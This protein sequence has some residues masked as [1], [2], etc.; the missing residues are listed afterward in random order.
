MATKEGDVE[1]IREGLTFKRYFTTEGTAPVRR[2]GLGDPRRGDPQLQGGRQRLRA[3]RR[4]VPHLLVAERHQ[5]RGPEVLPRDPRDARSAS[6]RVRQLAGRVVDTIRGWGEKNGYFASRGGRPGLR[7]GA[8]APHRHPEGGLQ[9][10]GLV[11]RRRAR[12]AA[13]VLRLLHPRGRRPHELHPQLVRRGGHHLQGRVGLRDQ[14]LA[15]SA[16][17]R[18][19]S[20]GAA[21][22]RA[23]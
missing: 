1:V 14:P 7:R 20:P 2:R 12:H 17:P 23:R 19:R 9:L 4:G 16:R 8:H 22:P 11:Q 18:S 5:H 15:R 3:A 10:A 6:P 13:A 21:P